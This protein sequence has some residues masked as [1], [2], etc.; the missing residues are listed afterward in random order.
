[1][2]TYYKGNTPTYREILD[3][4]DNIIKDYPLNNCGYFG[5][6]GKAGN[7]QIRQIYCN[8]PIKEAQKFYNIVAFGGIETNL[9]N[10]MGVRTKLKDGTVITYRE[11]TSTK[12]SPA[13]EI[14]I[15]KSNNHGNIKPQKI[16]FERRK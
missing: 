1:M 3:N 16:H 12:D 15:N 4:I 6:K 8:D 5:E 7:C 13:V 11:I 9:Q 10:N 14:N 2:G